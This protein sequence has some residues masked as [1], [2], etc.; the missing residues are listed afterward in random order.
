[1]VPFLFDQPFWGA[2]THA[3]GVG[4]APIPQKSLT[5]GRLAHAIHTATTDSRIRQ[6][7]RA[8]GEV[9]RAEDGI[10]NAVKAI[11]RYLGAPGSADRE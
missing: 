9:I 8:C 5:A 7:A 4:P 2:R 3:L 10:A 1:V 11:E 6:R